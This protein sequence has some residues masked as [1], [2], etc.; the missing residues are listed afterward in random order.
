MATE[1]EI[2]DLVNYYANLLIIQYHNK[3]KAVATI[4]A[5]TRETIASAVIFDVRDGY[6][7]EAAIGSQLDILGK[8]IGVDRFYAGTILNGF[9]SF[10]PYSLFSAPPAEFIGLADYADFEIKVGDLATYD[11]VINST[12]ALSDTDYR[13]LLKLKIII[14]NCNFSDGE[15]NQLIFDFFGTTLIPRSDGN[16]HMDYFYNPANFAII[17]IARNKELLPKPMGVG[18]GY[19]IPNLGYFSFVSYDEFDSPASTK[20]GLANY[21]DYDT[22][23]GNLLNYS[24]LM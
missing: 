20:I 7:V 18:I 1:T 13:F 23:D 5:I 6:D 8:Y 10:V 14:N 2:N 16:M 24:N 4:E 17:N 11:S 15:I 21:S 12:F 3:D 9:F 19:L 22:K